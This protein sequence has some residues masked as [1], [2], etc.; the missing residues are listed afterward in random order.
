MSKCSTKYGTVGSSIYIAKE[1]NIYL[2]LIKM[3]KIYIITV[4]NIWTKKVNDIC[5][6]FNNSLIYTLQFVNDQAI[7]VNNKDR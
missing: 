3:F 5:I 7:I 4:L 1:T 2:L 6:E